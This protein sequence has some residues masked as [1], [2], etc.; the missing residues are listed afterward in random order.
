MVCIRISSNSE[1][2][3]GKAV[4]ACFRWESQFW[5]EQ[6]AGNRCNNE[7]SENR[8]VN[9]GDTNKGRSGKVE[10]TSDEINQHFGSRG[11]ATTFARATDIRSTEDDSV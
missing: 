1:D 4:G 8:V 9:R 11:R 10:E 2:R 7:P 5:L 6:V 3:V